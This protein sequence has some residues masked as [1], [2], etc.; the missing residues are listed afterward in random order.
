M[1]SE[2]TEQLKKQVKHY[3]WNPPLGSEKLEKKEK[4]QSFGSGEFFRMC[5]KGVPIDDE[6]KQSTEFW[7][8][9]DASVAAFVQEKPSF[10]YFPEKVSSFASYLR[11]RKEQGLP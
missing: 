3:P 9:K 4:K 7:P 10:G 5:K 1:T 2:V 6:K 8:Q 11:K